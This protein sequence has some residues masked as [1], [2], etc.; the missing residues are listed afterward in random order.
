MKLLLSFLALLT[1]AACEP[2]DPDLTIITQD[3]KQYGYDIEVAMTPQQQQ[4]GMMGRTTMDKHFGMFFWFGGAEEER[5][6]WMK[7]VPIPLDILFIDAN[8][9]IISIANGKPD[10]PTSLLSNGPAAAALEI[11]GG[12]AAKRGIKPGDT[13]HFPLLNNAILR[14]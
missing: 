7:N 4:K 1:L 8:G 3:G 6:F 11:N 5:S 9:K 2:K 12:Q 13:V 10:D 14:E